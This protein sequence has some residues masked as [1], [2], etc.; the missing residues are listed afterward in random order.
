MREKKK[1]RHPRSICKKCGGRMLAYFSLV[2]SRIVKDD[3]T[4]GDWTDDGT[5]D[6][7]YYQCEACN[8]DEDA[9]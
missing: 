1:K 8:H 7:D 3:G 5:S 6:L 9:Y 2:R 4:L